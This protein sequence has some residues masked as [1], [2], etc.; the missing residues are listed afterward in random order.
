M[1]SYPILVGR[2]N[3]HWFDHTV[4]S[5]CCKPL[6][7]QSARFGIPHAS[8]AGRCLWSHTIQSG[9]PVLATYLSQ[10]L[11]GPNPREDSRCCQTSGS[12]NCL[13]HPPS[14]TANISVSL[15]TCAFEDQPPQTREAEAL[16]SSR[17]CSYV[18]LSRCN[19]SVT[20]K[21]SLI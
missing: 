9:S 20:Q 5:D 7:S 16:Q 18:N 12:V 14:Q 4:F 10:L 15:T 11:C 3:G 13:Q 17:L 21:L 19:T 8:S 6:M 1:V 2:H